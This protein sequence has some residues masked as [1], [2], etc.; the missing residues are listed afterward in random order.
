L[1][2]TIH[3]NCSGF[4]CIPVLQGYSIFVNEQY[5]S[6]FISKNLPNYSTVEKDESLAWARKGMISTLIAFLILLP[7]R[8][9]TLSKLKINRNIIRKEYGN[10]IIYE[11][12][13]YADDLKFG[14][15][16]RFFTLPEYLVP[17]FD[18]YVTVCRP[19]LL[20]GRESEYFFVDEHGGIDQETIFEITT[21]YTK[22]YLGIAM[23]PHLF[24]YYKGSILK[25]NPRLIIPV[26]EILLDESVEMVKE[27][28]IDFE[29]NDAMKSISH[30]RNRPNLSL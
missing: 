28:Y 3:R 8:C 26:T 1:D 11:I 24:R 23:N 7:A 14:K 29:I 19:A 17:I 16:D 13:I 12:F 2:L 9:K 15:R 21:Y 27:R 10:K 4:L 18:W 20:Q 6:T 25:K 30:L 22:K 5:V